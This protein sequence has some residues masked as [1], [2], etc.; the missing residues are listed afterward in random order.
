MGVATTFG[1]LILT[2][3]LLAVAVGEAVS[4]SDI[5]EAL[6][7]GSE[8]LV[9][10]GTSAWNALPAEGPAAAAAMK[11]K[12]RAIFRN[13][14]SSMKSH[15]EFAKVGSNKEPVLVQAGWKF[16]DMTAA[17]GFGHRPVGAKRLIKRIA[18]R[19]S[20]R[21]IKRAIRQAKSATSAGGGW[22]NAMAKAPVRLKLGISRRR[23][24]LVAKSSA[25]AKKATLKAKKL[26][27]A[28]KKA[29]AAIG[30]KPWLGYSHGDAWLDKG[31]HYH[32]GANRRRIG[33]GFGRRRRGVKPTGYH[34]KPTIR[35]KK[36][37]S[38]HRMFSNRYGPHRRGLRKKHGIWYCHKCIANFLRDKGCNAVLYHGKR[39]KTLMPPGCRRCSVAASKRCILKKKKSVAKPNTRRRRAAS[40][41]RKY[42]D[43]GKPNTL[44]C[45]TYLLRTTTGNK[46]HAATRHSPKIT[47]VGTKS[48]YHG[49][50]NVA[51][52]GGVAITKMRTGHIG[53]L[54]EIRL[55]AS[56]RDG[57]YFTRLE[58]RSCEFKS[59]VIPGRA[60]PGARWQDFGCTH[61][62]L[63]GKPFDK[64]FSYRAP[65]ADRIV[66]RRV[67]G[68][69]KVNSPVA[70]EARTKWMKR[71]E[72]IKA[73]A[74]VENAGRSRLLRRIVTGAS[75]A[76]IK[77]RYGRMRKHR[78]APMPVRVKRKTHDA[79]GCKI[80]KQTWCA[81]LAKCIPGRYVCKVRL[82]EGAWGNVRLYVKK[83]LKKHKKKHQGPLKFSLPTGFKLRGVE[84]KSKAHAKIKA[85]AKKAAL[86]KLYGGRRRRFL[87]KLPH[88]A[89]PK[90]P[91]DPR[92][93]AVVKE[94]AANEEASSAV[95]ML[96]ASLSPKALTKSMKVMKVRAAASTDLDSLLSADLQQAST[97]DKQHQERRQKRDALLKYKAD[98][99]KYDGHFDDLFSNGGRLPKDVRDERY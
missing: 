80:G 51:G 53:A 42:I 13:A 5:D 97:E 10:D 14:K 66:L 55:E 50:L 40:S 52:A 88:Y 25:A 9:Q 99:H 67:A 94:E 93:M 34:P 87:A 61:R 28:A 6:P 60:A 24:T 57:W 37:L 49:I 91:S 39:A 64:H 74:W 35:S 23:R 85:Q 47:L 59:D 54:V 44:G 63:D 16:G 70:K 89:M 76:R 79:N 38:S 2:S 15:E 56:S 33:A 45:D 1:A 12:M 30:K 36:P 81:P 7:T 27:A 78:A 31:G 84:L 96:G 21:K 98:Q 75:E 19:E 32:L 82:S 3:A 65:Y 95:S 90:K 29:K 17:I 41:P 22:E 11:H 43:A 18:K 71:S 69:C 26:K 73:K 72:G 68:Q 86:K 8:S 92:G 83:S 4:G 20:K 46:D 62:W 48:S 77:A 58:T